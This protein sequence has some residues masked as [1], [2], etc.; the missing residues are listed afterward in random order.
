MILGNPGV[1]HSIPTACS[2]YGMGHVWVTED[3]END[4]HESSGIPHYVA[5]KDHSLR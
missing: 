3:G 1:T 5:S 4:V 2:G